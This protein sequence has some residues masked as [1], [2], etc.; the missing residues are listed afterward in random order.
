[1][2]NS[3]TG[4]VHTNFMQAVAATGRLSSNQPNLQ[5]IPIRTSRGKEIRK[6]FVARDENHVLV[7]AAAA[8]RCRAA[9]AGGACPWVLPRQYRAASG[10]SNIPSRCLEILN[11]IVSLFFLIFSSFYF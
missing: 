7:S 11:S 4:R 8:S 3:I 6:A 2:I 5:N 10:L 9:H 1:M